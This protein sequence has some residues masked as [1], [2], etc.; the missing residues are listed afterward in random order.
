MREQAYRIS[1][2][3][4]ETPENPTMYLEIPEEN[5]PLVPSVGQEKFSERRPAEYRTREARFQSSFRS[6]TGKS[7]SS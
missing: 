1:S 5:D 3:E 6:I 2:S 4:V 7:N